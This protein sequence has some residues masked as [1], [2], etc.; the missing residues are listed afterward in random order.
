[1]LIG[2]SQSVKADAEELHLVFCGQLA[3]KLLVAIGIGT[4]QLKI[5]VRHRHLQPALRQQMKHHNRVGATAH[6][7]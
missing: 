2:V 5:A 3:Y 7:R 4:A 1:M 6:G